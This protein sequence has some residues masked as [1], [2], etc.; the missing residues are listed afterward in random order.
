[1][2]LLGSSTGPVKVTVYRRS[3]G[4]QTQREL[5]VAA[6]AQNGLIGRNFEV[7]ARRRL[8]SPPAPKKSGAHI[9]PVQ[10]ERPRYGNG[11]VSVR[12]R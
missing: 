9:L 2:V 7:Q 6:L 1:M 8:A 5:A 3:D 11:V 12:F 10:F 4:Q